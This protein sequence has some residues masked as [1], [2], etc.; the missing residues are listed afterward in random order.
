MINEKVLA[1]QLLNAVW[2]EDVEMTKTVLAAGG[3]PNWIFNGYPILLH[4]VF[5]ANKEMVMTLIDAG[6]SQVEEALG[7]ALDR[8]IGEIVFPL[9]FL[10]IVPKVEKV[11]KEFGL[12]PSRYCPLHYRPLAH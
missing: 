7:F 5:T 11:E 3:D 6:A 4:A 12:Y 10:G 8:G 1:K 9:A 2:E